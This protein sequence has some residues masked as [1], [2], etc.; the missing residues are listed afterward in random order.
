MSAG[1]EAI[2][3]RAGSSGSIQGPAE[4]SWGYTVPSVADWDGD[5]FLDVMM[6]DIWGHVR[7]YRNPGR[8]GTLDL[9]PPQPVEVEW[10]GATPELAWG[11]EKPKGKELLAQWRTRALM[12]DWNKDG[13]ADLIMLDHEGYLAW[14]ERFR[15]P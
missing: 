4:R 6:N 11:W 1:G 13:L 9:E 12:Y 10:N 15:K 14:F 5:G 7:L 8:K 3:I 2:N